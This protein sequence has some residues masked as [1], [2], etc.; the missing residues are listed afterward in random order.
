MAPGTKILLAVLALIAVGIFAYYAAIPQGERPATPDPS[1]EETAAPDSS[2]ADLP[3]TEESQTETAPSAPPVEQPTR[4]NESPASGQP[5]LGNLPAGGSGSEG[6]LADSVRRALAADNA[7]AGDKP[8]SSGP[9]E[10]AA[11]P[12]ASPPR[13]PAGEGP[14]EEPAKPPSTPEEKP[15]AATEG[16]EQ[17]PRPPARPPEP[18]YTEYQVKAGDTLS[19]IAGNWF[20]DPNKWDLI[21]RANPRI[22]PDNLDIGQKLR[23]PPKTATR[24]AI[25]PQ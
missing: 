23:L 16:Q 1:T 2:Q 14:A 4:V 9:I 12:E 10:S 8:L 22:D 19:S 13:Q 3:A 7:E 20:G 17:P 21:Y 25:R 18:L 6:G 15:P 5:P 24:Q 11:E